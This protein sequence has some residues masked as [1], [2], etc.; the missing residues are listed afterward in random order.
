MK[1][2]FLGTLSLCLLFTSCSSGVSNS[3]YK[4]IKAELEECRKTVEELKNSPQV[5]LSNIQ[6]Y[7]ANNDFE[8]A[9]KESNSLNEKFSQSD[10]ARKATSLIEEF[11]KKEKAKKEAEERK[12]ALGFKVLIE[13]NSVTVGDVQLNFNSVNTGD[14]WTFDRYGR[15]YHYYGAERGNVFILANVAISSEIK[16]PKL[17]PVAVYKISNGSLELIDKLGYRFSKWE[18]FGTYLGNNS[19]YGNDFSHTKTI[20]FSMGLSI[21]QSDLK[22]EI[23]F[24]VVKNENCINRST[25]R[26]ENPPVSYASGN[27]AIKSTL[28]VYDFDNDYVLVKIFNKNKL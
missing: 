13:K 23:L 21:S 8:N 20:S 9:K 16:E 14:R 4:K 25:N 17:P 27:C 7:L 12:K 19:D 3:E 1:R 2:L 5:R 11:E 26:F 22:N 24:V 28:T 10:E 18:D 6:Q 15:E